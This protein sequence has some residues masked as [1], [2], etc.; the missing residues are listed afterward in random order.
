MDVP[1]PRFDVTAPAPA[2]DGLGHVHL[3]AIGGAGMSAVATLL[4][5]RGLEVSGSDRVEGTALAGLRAAGAT[6]FVGHAAEHVRGADTV[7]VSSAITEDNVELAAAREAGLLVLHRSQALA[8]T[9]SGMRRI[10][11]AGANGKTTTTSMLTVA[12]VHAGVDPSFAVGAEIGQLATNAA[13][14]RGP[15]FVVEADESDGSFLAYRP[16]VAIVTNVQPDHLDFYGTVAAVHQAYVEFA[17]SITD[18]GLLVASHDD[19]GSRALAERI[20]ASGLRVVTYGRDAGA[21][22]QIGASS[23][24]GLGTRTTIH[25]RGATHSLELVVPGRHNVENACAALLAA[26]EGL[27]QDIGEVLNG[28][29][30][31]TGAR[32]RFEV[33]GEVRGVTVVDDYAHNAPKVA[34]VVG[35]AAEVVRRS[36]NGALRVIFQPHLYSRTRDFAA[37]FAQALAPA[38]DVVV[39]DVFG[40]REA[41]MDGVTSALIGNPLAA[42]ASGPQRVEVGGSMDEAAARVA[43]R[44]VTG[45]LVLTVGAGDVTRLATVVLEALAESGGGGP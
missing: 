11:V 43:R 39:L 38:D 41:P 29:L 22:L 1:A 17:E 3:I 31:F 25:H 10:A 4:L 18:G 28:L 7:V 30:T 42:L 21:D 45:D 5:A 15:D 32:R 8:A 16:D 35:T 9:M 27:G 37:E 6:V 2:L 33:R 13:I 24:R 12:L 14:G 19:P 34:A 40:A 44:S 23:S 20:A 36:G 26:T